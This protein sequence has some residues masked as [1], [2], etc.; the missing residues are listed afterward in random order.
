MTKP[1]APDLVTVTLP[2]RAA[3]TPKAAGRGARGRRK[4]G[5]GG[6]GLLGK[7]LL[8]GSGNREARRSLQSRVV[9]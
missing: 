7:W 6:V 5:R 1:R 9:H 2:S 3:G 4:E 8:Q